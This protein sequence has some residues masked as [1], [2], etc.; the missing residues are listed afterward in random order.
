MQTNSG[1]SVDETMPDV[2]LS[3][4]PT[5]LEPFEAA[6]DHQWWAGWQTVAPTSANGDRMGLPTGRIPASTSMDNTM[7]DLKKPTPGR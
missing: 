6:Q 4:T 2:L 1:R 3:H 5:P 7:W